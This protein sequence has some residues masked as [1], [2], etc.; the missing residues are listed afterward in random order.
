MLFNAQN[1]LKL[2]VIA[3]NNPM[4]EKLIKICLHK[5]VEYII[6]PLKKQIWYIFGLEL[7]YKDGL[8]TT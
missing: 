1:V 6:V 4:D 2:H 5:K 8:D 3:P 7:L